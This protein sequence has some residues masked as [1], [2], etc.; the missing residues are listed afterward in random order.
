MKIGLID[1]DSHN[2]PNLALMKISAYHKLKGDD[3]EICFG[4][5][6]YHK[7]YVSKVFTFTKDYNEY[8]MS[9]EIIKG[10]TGYNLTS[11]LPIEI[12][13]MFPDYSL[14][15][16]KDT[17]YGYLTRGCPRGCDFC[18]VKDKEGQ[19][20]IKVADLKNFWNGQKNIVLLDPN[21][22][23]YKNCIDLLQQLVDS[24]SNIDFSQGLDIRLM[25]EQ[26]A[27]MINNMKITRL[28]F[29]WDKFSDKFV[30]DC[31]KKYRPIF[32]LNR[33][34][35]CVYILTNFN[36]TFEEDLERVYITRDL[37][38]DPYVMIYD[39]ENAPK[40]TRYL[41]RWVNNRIIFRTVPKFED[42]DRK[43]G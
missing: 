10:G 34:K 18:I 31:L 2:F 32:K 22:L 19:Q 25:T 15:N 20:S 24:K 9:D 6:K 33:Q 36:S 26:K 43:Q 3:V 23:A 28:H 39:K 21:I 14:Y 12:E 29:A 40:K 1:V 11:K 41:Q 42:Y 7:V 16:I 17:A 30:V 13:N 35:L 4:L 27:Q 5:K 37:G 38:Y 8:I